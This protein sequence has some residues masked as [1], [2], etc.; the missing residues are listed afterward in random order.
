M[1]T[2]RPNNACRLSWLVEFDSMAP[3]TADDANAQRLDW[4]ILRDG[5]VYLYRRPEFLDE[6]RGWLESNDY[7]LI[8]FDCAEW[9]SESEMHRALKEGLSFPDY[10]GNNLNAFD[11]CVRDD[12]AIPDPGGLVLVL[13]H[14]DRF[15]KSVD[16]GT[17]KGQGVADAIL[18]AFA[19]AI[20]RHMLF[21]KRLIILVQSD[22]PLI[23]FD[24]LGG[25]RAT[26]NSREWLNKNRGL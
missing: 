3:F 15:A 17:P 14:Y 24:G 12:L 18:D 20:R 1:L 23:V 10:Y 19:R 2:T 9:G 4:A 21:G 5:G 11:E 22:D 13:N 7:R 25:V 26:W 16:V 6:D 8:W